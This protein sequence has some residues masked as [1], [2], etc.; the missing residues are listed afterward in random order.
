MNPYKHSDYALKM[1]ELNKIGTLK[2]IDFF[3]PNKFEYKLIYIIGLI[4]SW[5]MREEY[6]SN[7][8]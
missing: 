2:E 1:I 4:L 8:L 6:V 7:G 5:L 3:T